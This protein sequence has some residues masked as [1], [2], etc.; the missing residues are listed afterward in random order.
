MVWGFVW[1]LFGIILNE[2]CKLYW[3]FII[4]VAIREKEFSRFFFEMESK[5]HLLKFNWLG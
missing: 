1:D 2:L 4:I 5:F 3:L